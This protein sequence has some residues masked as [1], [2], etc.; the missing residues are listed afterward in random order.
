[1]SARRAGGDHGSG[2]G[3]HAGRHGAAAGRPG[4]DRSGC[5]CRRRDDSPALPRPAARRADP[6]GSGVDNLIG[7]VHYVDA[8]GKTHLIDSKL[9]FPNGI[10]L[11]PGGKKLLVAESQKNRILAYEVTGPGKV[12]QRTVFA[13]LPNKDT[14]AGHINAT[15]A[16]RS[17]VAVAPTLVGATTYARTACDSS[18]RQ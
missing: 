17:F 14:S 7:T 8:A 4:S 1:M 11:L 3:G 10:V 13:R 12:G 16:G 18:P 5:W 2:G 9:A 15:A 6:G